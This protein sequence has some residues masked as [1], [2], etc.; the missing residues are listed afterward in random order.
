MRDA[1]GVIFL[2]KGDGRLG[3]LEQRQ[4]DEGVDGVHLLLG[5]AV[6]LVGLIHLGALEDHE[7]ALGLGELVVL[8]LGTIH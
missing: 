3:P 2:V 6:L 1:V 5:D 4:G 7:A 8:L